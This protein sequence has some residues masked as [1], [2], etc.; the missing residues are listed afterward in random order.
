MGIYY[1]IKWAMQYGFKLITHQV[2]DKNPFHRWISWN[3]PP[4]ATEYILYFT[5]GNFTLDFSTGKVK[6]AVHRKTFGNKDLMKLSGPN[7]NDVS[8]EMYPEIV[9]FPITRNRIHP[10]QK[11]D[12]FSPMFHRILQVEKVCDPMCGCGVLLT[13]FSEATG[14]DIIDYEKYNPLDSAKYRPKAKEETEKNIS[15]KVK[16]QAR[17]TL[18][19]YGNEKKSKV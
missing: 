16:V 1:H 13:S 17:L 8:Y 6:P 7:R 3:S 10:V 15:N 14:I 4:H 9:H 2:W 12:D 5:K 19:D 18:G 11:P